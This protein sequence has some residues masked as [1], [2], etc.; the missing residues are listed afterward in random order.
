MNF[1]YKKTSS[2]LTAHL[3]LIDTHLIDYCGR[4]KTALHQTTIPALSYLNDIDFPLP[5][6]EAN[7]L[8]FAHVIV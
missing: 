4:L 2:I 3:R 7:C 8:P 1:S 6:S 5:A